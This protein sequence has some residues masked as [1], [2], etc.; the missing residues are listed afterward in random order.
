[1]MERIPPH[2]NEAEM[3]VLGAAM[4]SKDAL[5]DIME[6]V[7]AKDFYS[8]I[9]GEI[10]EVITSLYRSSKPVDTV[11]VSEELKK[12]NWNI[13]GRLRHIGFDKCRC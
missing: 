13:R 2:N 11:T 9:H 6:V 1:M 5:F 4:L 8:E 12:R 3:S 7:R 10:F